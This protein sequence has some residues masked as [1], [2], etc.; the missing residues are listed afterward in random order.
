MKR[1]L[2]FLSFY[3]CLLS[4]VQ[5]QKVGLVL[6]GG[7]AKGMTHIG[8]IRALEENN[9]PIDY[10]T[11]TSM[12]AIIGSLYAMGYSPDDMEALL[13]S[14]DFKRWYSGKVEPKYEYYFKKNRP[15]PEFFNIRFAFRDSMH[16]K[17]QI[18]PTSMV[19][20][21]QMNL[22]FVELFA[23]ATAS[24][25]GDF[26]KLFVPF[27]CIASDV[28]NK[29]PLIMRKG[30]LGD[31]V[32]ASMSFP[33]VFK[34]IEI[35][36]V[37]AY[38]GG[39]YN[40]FPTDVM[41]ED[42]CPDI[43]IGSVVAANPSKPKENDL[44]S[45]IENMVM[46]KTDYSLPDSLGIIMN[47]K[48]DDVNLLDFDRLQEL[49]DIGYNRTI[50]LMDS[51]KNRIH[52]RV[53]ADNVRL[54][55]LVYRSNLPQL[56][57]RDIRIEGANEQQQVYI[58]KEFHDEDH[59]VF[60]YEDLKRGYFRLLADNMI[61]EI[62]PHAVYDPENDLY[63]LH[64]KVK[65]ENNFSVRMGGSVS[66]TSSNQIYLGLGYQNL[67]YYSK[68]ITFDGQLGKVYNNAQL[69]AKIDLPTR[70]PTSYRFIAS[71][72]TFD[73]YKKDKLF[74]KNDKPSFNSKDERFVKLMVA[75]P[76]L[77]NKRA[78]FSIGYGALEDNYFQSNVINFDEDRSDKSTY[79]LLSGTIGFYG[80]TYNA[81]QYATRGY[82][83]KLIAQVFTGK[84]K[85]RP[86]NPKE[87]VSTK[88]RQS[89]L[90]ISYMKDA[91]HSMSPKFTL[92]WMAEML[93]S[94]KNFSENYTA[95]M[96]Q[97]AEFTP[98]PHSKLMYNEAF[99]ANQFLAVGI[100]PIFIFNDMF[101]FR[102]EFYGFMPVFPIEKNALNKAFYGKAFS[103]F[104]YM[105]E[106]SVICQLPFG[107]IAAYVNHYSS[108]KKEWNVGLTI[109]WQLFNY[110]FIE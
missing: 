16:L 30:D 91:Y 55:R 101:Q 72:S 17:P 70:I 20:P 110:R 3:L 22:V 18:L 35:D 107:T 9:I 58:K 51:I 7:G 84:E 92:G 52:R 90:Q 5:A 85:F 75:L 41:R 96:M 46:Q 36:S 34:P 98:T 50:S 68:E 86:G 8:I 28:Y 40:N 99:R 2:L 45:Q 80:S 59:E 56:R 26:N 13:R 38:D 32:R 89:W 48:Y 19:N 83:E 10:I 44:M 6:S 94:S 74:S 1:I 82:Y 24:C 81:R 47:F 66:T 64:L 100:K 54:R 102:T 78:E 14:P 15:T 11:G 109:G 77:S 87:E 71:I 43:I 95:T 57:F 69:M 76:F 37:L 106:I 42:F 65:M 53:N 21:I 39:I 25:N 60:T 63:E 23:R 108:P 31:A 62:I 104:E 97:A 12:G 4:V 61:S 29:R 33:F 93:Y 73:Y 67:N 105:G 103:K 27:R 88:G 49:H 79:K